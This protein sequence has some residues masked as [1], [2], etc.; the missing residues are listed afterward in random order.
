MDDV[1]EQHVAIE[2]HGA[3][4]RAVASISISRGKASLRLEKGAED[5]AESVDKLQMMPFAEFRHS[6]APA[7]VILSFAFGRFFRL[8]NEPLVAIA[9][10]DPSY[11]PRDFVPYLGVS[12]HAS[13]ARYARRANRF[14]LRCCVRHEHALYRCGCPRPARLN[15]SAEGDDFKRDAVDALATDWRGSALG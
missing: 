6:V 14:D 13:V 1:L 7:E 11:I 12:E 15:L 9:A 8:K 3:N 10:L 5:V 4:W 2:V